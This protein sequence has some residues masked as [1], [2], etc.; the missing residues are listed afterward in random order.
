MVAR[1]WLQPVP[2]APQPHALAKRVELS[3]GE[4]SA[5]TASH[6]HKGL[7]AKSQKQVRGRRCTL[8]RRCPLHG[9]G[10][11]QRAHTE[12]NMR[13]PLHVQSTD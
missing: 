1:C 5:D 11:T 12:G 13:A 3:S 8:S 4:E 10:R 6:A 7:F 9:N 2:R